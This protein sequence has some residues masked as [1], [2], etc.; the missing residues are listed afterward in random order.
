MEI[1]ECVCGVAAID[2]EYH[3]P[4]YPYPVGTRIKNG[5]KWYRVVAVRA[6]EVYSM[7]IELNDE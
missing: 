4:T 3:K 6:G 2:C 1:N 7:R 5:N